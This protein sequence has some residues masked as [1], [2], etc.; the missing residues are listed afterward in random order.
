MMRLHILHVCD[1]G[2]RD[3]LS[4]AKAHCIIVLKKL[5]EVFPKK[6]TKAHVVLAV[7]KLRK[8]ITGVTDEELLR[9]PKMSDV[10][11]LAVM[12]ILNVMFLNVYF[13]DPLLAPLV[14]VRMVIL[15][16]DHGLSSISSAGF[17]IFGALSCSCGS[18]IEFGYRCGQLALQLL[19]MFKCA[20]FLPRV[21]S[22]V[23]GFINSWKFDYSAAL[24]PL[25]CAHHIGLET[26]D[27]EFAM[28]NATISGVSFRSRSRP[29]PRSH[30][31][32]CLANRSLALLQ[33]LHSTC[34]FMP[35]S[36]WHTVKTK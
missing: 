33:I 6:P 34:P 15:S 29:R 12:Q 31:D 11:K 18:D 1:L 24:E 27:I 8:R 14:A 32:S 9:L 30:H 3:K 20:E 25:R 2:A 7:L 10:N 17:A 35:G 16:L 19:E 4:E 36:P 26:G 23:Y 21:Y 28:V 13:A 22:A 5:G